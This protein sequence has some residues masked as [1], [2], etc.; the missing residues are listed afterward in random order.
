MFGLRGDRWFVCSEVAHI[1]ELVP[2]KVLNT[3]IASQPLFI[4]S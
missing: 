1:N 4:I 3:Y 2:I